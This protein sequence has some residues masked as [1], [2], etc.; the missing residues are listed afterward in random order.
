[1]PHM[2]QRLRSNGRGQ[3]TSLLQDNSNR[4]CEGLDEAAQMRMQWQCLYGD[5]GALRHVCGPL[6]DHMNNLL[7]LIVSEM[8]PC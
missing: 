4:G 6:S 3:F 1:M 8:T 5:N 2:A 7:P